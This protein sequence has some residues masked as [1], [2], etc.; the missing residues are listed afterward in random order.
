[1]I[2][3]DSLSL[4]VYESVIFEIARAKCNKEKHERFT[5]DSDV[6]K[7][8]AGHEQL[9]ALKVAVVHDPGEDVGHFEA[10]INRRVVKAFS[11]AATKLQTFTSPIAEAT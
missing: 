2:V 6:A 4:I 9:S 5:Y 10:V 1:M 8:G 3:T 7:R 11:I